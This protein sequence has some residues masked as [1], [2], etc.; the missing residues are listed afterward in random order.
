MQGREGEE[1]FKF[2]AELGNEFNLGKAHN[3]PLRTIITF[4]VGGLLIYMAFYLHQLAQMRKILR[5]PVTS[6]WLWVSK[7]GLVFLALQFF[8]SLTFVP[9]FYTSYKGL[10]YTFIAVY[11]LY[12]GLHFARNTHSRQQEAEFTRDIQ[13]TRFIPKKAN[14]ILK[15]KSS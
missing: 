5:I 4:G 3:G 10:V 1:Y 14:H 9:P 13:A 11:F 15:H 7:G 8:S 6:R 12:A 2:S